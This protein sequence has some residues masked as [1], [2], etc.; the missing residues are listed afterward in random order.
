MARS[1][2]G[3]LLSQRKC[4]LDLLSEA[5]M[6]GYKSIDFPMDMNT[7]HIEDIGQYRRLMKKL[8]Y[9]TVTRLD[10]TF[11]VSVVSQFLLAPRTTGLGK[12]LEDN[13]HYK[14]LVKKL[15]YLTVIRSDITFA[16]SVMSQF[17]LTPRTTHS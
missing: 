2:K 16:V 1:K 14:R 13:G 5:G 11:I 6:L 15:T 17:L 4:V 12:L 3:I 9:L 8:T 7:K 10:I